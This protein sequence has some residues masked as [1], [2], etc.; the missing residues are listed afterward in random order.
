MRMRLVSLALTLLAIS[1]F[2]CGSDG[3]RCRAFK[4]T[5]RTQLIGGT[6]ALAELGDYVI[7]NDRIRVAITQKGNSVG[8]GVFGGSLIDADV[9]RPQAEF[10]NGNGLDQL[11]EIFPIGNL[12]IP[13]MCNRGEDGKIDQ[14]CADLPK[15]V[16]PEI[17][18]L[19]DG[20]RPCRLDPHDELNADYA[21]E[22][23]WPTEQAAV[24][25]VVG[26]SGNYL[27]ALGLVGLVG[28]KMNFRIRNDYILE[29]GSN[30]VRMR[31]LLMEA[32]SDGSLA[33]PH[34]DVMKLPSLK[35]STAIFGLL[36]G[37]SLFPT[38]LPNMQPGLAGGDFLFFGERTKVFGHGVGFDIY[39]EIRDK[40]S[41]GQDPF[42]QPIAAD[43][44]ASVG[45]GVSYAIAS[46]D[47]DGK[48]LLP[49][50]SGAVT[51][52]FTHGAHCYSGPCPGTP[53]QCENVIDCNS[54]LG[55][56][57][58]RLFAVGDGDIASAAAAIYQARGQTLGHVEGHVIDRRTARPVPKAEI[59]VYPVPE[60]MADCR[61]GGSAS[62]PYTGGPEHFVQ[63]CLKP[64][65]FKGIVNHM[66]ADR[67]ATEVLP[68][69][70]FEGWLP[71]GH[72]YL[73]AKA[74]WRPV[75]NVVP[76]EITESATA[77]VTLALEQPARVRYE[78]LDEQNRHVPAKLT[79]GQCFPECS[80][81]FGA[82]CE[83]GSDCTS[84]KCVDD[85]SGQL[86][87]L[88]DN[89]PAERFCNLETLRC[90][91]LEEC[92]SDSQCRAAER[93][94]ASGDG[95][96]RCQ[97]VGGFA[98]QKSLGEGSY[99]PGLGRYQYTADG[100]GEFEIE[101][102][103]YEIIASRG[104]EYSVD[105]KSVDLLPGQTVE[106]SFRI[107]R[108]VDTSGWMSGD[109]HVHG[110]N[111]YDAVV[112]H[113]D[114]VIAF[115]G[116]GVEVLSTSDHDYVTDLEPY[117]LELGLQNWVYTQVG[118]EL[119]TV[120]LGHFIG[121]PFRYEEW[122]SGNRVREQG[123]IDWTGK[124]PDRL[125]DELRS[126]GLY[127]PDDTVVLVAHPR[128]SFFGY[129]DQYGLSAFDPNKVEG[130]LFEWLPPLYSNP[131][132]DPENFSGRFDALELFNSKRFELIRTP[133]QAEIRAYNQQRKVI[134]LEADRGA[135]PDLVER[136]LI[137]LDR[138]FIKQILERT[139]EEQRLV[140][141]S[142]GTDGCELVAFCTNQQDCSAGQVCDTENY[143]CYT[144]CTDG[145]DCPSGICAGGRCE[146]QLPDGD[147]PCTSHE[148][149]IDDW[150]R[151]LDY[152]VV[153]TGMGN[154]DTHQLFTQTE[155]GCPRNF[156]KLS[157]ESPAGVDK[158]EL[159]RSVNSGKV[160][161]SYGPFVELWLE[162][163]E[164]GEVANTSGKQSL[165]LRIRVQS[166]PW[167]DVDRVEIYRSGELIHVI[168][169]A[170]DRLH[171]ELQIDTSGLQLPNPRV[172]N[173]DVVLPE[174]VPERDAWYVA[175]AMGLKGRDLSP[176]YAEHPYLKLQIGDILSRSFTSVPV[177]FDV[178]GAAVPRVFRVYP[179]A[180]TNP[181]FA[182]TDG[183]G[184]Y[185]SPHPPPRWAGGAQEKAVRE[186]PL[187]SARIGHSPLRPKAT[188]AAWKIRA[189][190][191]LLGRLHGATV[192]GYGTPD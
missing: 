90:E 79:V 9:R 171:P 71:V 132:A 33:H 187:S 74:N 143:Q 59:F 63:E 44:L 134:Q 23:S 72:Y 106:L 118:L 172:V 119:T 160:V 109:F 73:L 49:L 153:R 13:A 114:R 188:K 183:N 140:W 3:Q 182:D 2:G 176:V 94:L 14:Y 124:K 27:E 47:P 137:A 28:V 25:R 30:V 133:T 146:Q 164:I 64:R 81:H 11:S 26:Q 189:L 45:E 170:G 191:Y 108:V 50:Y 158:L 135:P 113:R 70:R 117:V 92:T 174:P 86:R 101:A 58:E 139:P 20:E 41:S 19:C 88:V 177:P 32:R 169:A 46:A 129:F 190:R 65:N 22:G 173:L 116:E 192:Y 100:F 157:A 8:P 155:A 185:D 43:F 84:G 102:G 34:G 128:D 150:F 38:E 36:L 105:R 125:F 112:K 68:E 17:S 97:C 61:P 78:V 103:S 21:D 51:A 93:C 96:R 16:E 29:P 156:I 131:L 120:E 147:A 55:V 15:G 31:T 154:S 111:S 130:T 7:E 62:E 122:N 24:I 127:G 18:I 85:G 165:D 83:R 60:T 162:G 56:Y 121:F 57:F 145:S 40:F 163:A 48:Y 75:S 76:V 149:V 39:K 77:S 126:L 184:R 12:A 181:V 178:S 42:N 161:A 98:R 141:N 37:S 167:F 151:L 5:N 110:V 91:P 159:A 136:K 6:S 82:T 186:M 67:Q 152:G 66:R 53:E 148:G 54:L 166:P 115:A 87:C 4:I 80:G 123:A 175:I 35:K 52:G 179:Y 10:R 107:G 104:F 180:V 142:D 95:T 138:K 99:A 168:T 69:G 89:C 1:S 144:P